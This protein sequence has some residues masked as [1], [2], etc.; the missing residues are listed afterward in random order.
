LKKD[1]CTFPYDYEYKV[2]AEVEEYLKIN[3]IKTSR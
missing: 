3:K 1:S 2:S